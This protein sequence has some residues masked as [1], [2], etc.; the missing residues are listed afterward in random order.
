META[1]TPLRHGK[2]MGE[3]EPFRPR[4]PGKEGPVNLSQLPKGLRFLVVRR[5]SDR[6]AYY[7]VK[8]N[9]SGLVTFLATGNKVSPVRTPLAVLKVQ[10]GASY[11]VKPT[12]PEP[13]RRAA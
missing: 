8:T 9:G 2:S 1:P 10:G 3:A 5:I 13:L 4:S 11:E 12:E 7:Y 6:L